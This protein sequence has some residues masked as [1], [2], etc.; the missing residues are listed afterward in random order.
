MIEVFNISEGVFWGLMDL[1]E[2]A[3][4]KKIT[5]KR[6]IETQGKNHL[7][8]FLLKKAIP[9]HYDYNGKPYLKDDSKH[10]SISHSFGKLVIIVNEHQKTGIDI[11][12]IRDKVL[13]VKHKFLSL[14]ELEDAGEDIEKLLI[15]WSA[16]ETL[17]KI[18]GVKEI[19]FKEHLSVQPFIRYL[20][21]IIFG[22]IKL[23]NNDIKQFELH[24]RL[25]ENYVIVYCV[26]SLN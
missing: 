23:S 9:I 21:G 8:E 4:S 15:Y 2:F 24:Y 18:Y 20:S 25:I 13:N 3:I 6:E 12:I 1:N 22:S 14:S 11:E 26:K 17:Y 5:I 19:N 7:L 16:K 10:I